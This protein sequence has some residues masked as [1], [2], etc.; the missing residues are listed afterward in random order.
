MSF[1]IKKTWKII[2]DLQKLG[3]TLRYRQ[4]LFELEELSLAF[5]DSIIEGFLPYKNLW[6]GCQ[7]LVKL[8][9]ATVGNPIANIELQDVWDA[10]QVIK[11]SLHKSIE[12]FNEKPEIQ[13]VARFFLRVLD[14]FVPKYN[15]IKDLKNEN[16][17]YLHW[18]ELSLRSGM[19]IK[20]SMAMNFQYCMRKGMMDHLEL[21]HEVS[22][23]ATN[24]ADAIRKAWEEE[25]RRKEEELQA[26]L[27]RKA[28]RKCRTDIV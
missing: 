12:I 1:Q 21:V 4:E 13:E 7:D 27:L 20:Y 22:E 6:Y 2:K 18:Q 10:M 11:N 3:E 28:M 26:I 9:E 14:E 19:D 24:E 16:W 15:A 5:L 25:E 8:E 17:L 23:K